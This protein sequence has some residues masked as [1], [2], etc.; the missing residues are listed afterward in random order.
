M[1]TNE[2]LNTARTILGFVQWDIL[3]LAHRQ[4]PL[5]VLIVDHESTHAEKPKIVRVRKR[6]MQNKGLIRWGITLLGSRITEG[7]DL[8]LNGTV[9][10]LPNFR[11]VYTADWYRWVVS[12]YNGNVINRKREVIYKL[13]DIVGPPMCLYCD[14]RTVFIWSTKSKHKLNHARLSYS[15]RTEN[16]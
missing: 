10:H 3:M 13:R 15:A 9:L 12:H 8:Q 16:Q 14:K 4:L 5:R 11:A 7:I 6:L 1:M 2:A